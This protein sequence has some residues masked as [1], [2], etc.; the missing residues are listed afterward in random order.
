MDNLANKTDEEL[1]AIIRRAENTDVP[2]LYSKY[3]DILLAMAFNHL[4]I[5]SV[6][7]GCQNIYPSSVEK[8]MRLMKSMLTAFKMIW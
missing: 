5:K 4:G 8:P 7:D 3:T 2:K 1:E 6:N